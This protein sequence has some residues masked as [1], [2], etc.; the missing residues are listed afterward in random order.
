MNVIL[1][2][3]LFLNFSFHFA[4]NK[5]AQ[6]QNRKCMTGN[7]SIGLAVH[8]AMHFV[9]NCYSKLSGACVATLLLQCAIG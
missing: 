2:L 6:V 7:N 5:K 1:S 9:H 8:F 3:F 4:E